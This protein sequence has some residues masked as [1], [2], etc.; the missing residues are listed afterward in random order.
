MNVSKEQMQ[1]MYQTMMRIRKFELNAQ[2]DFANGK[3]SVSFISTWEE[4]AIATG[5]CENLRKDDFITKVH[6]EVMAI[7]SPRAV[8]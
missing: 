4:E 8:G 7:S 6:T 3:S 1:H 5:V 2:N